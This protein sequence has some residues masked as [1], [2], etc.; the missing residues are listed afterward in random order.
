MEGTHDPD[1]LIAWMDDLIQRIEAHA[2]YGPAMRKAAEDRLTLVLNYHTHGP[3]HG[4]CLSI[5]SRPHP[6]L[7]VLG[8]PSVL[9]ELVHVRGFG[10]TAEE[11]EPLLQLLSARLQSHYRLE[12]APEILIGRR[13]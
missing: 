2:S 12:K 9:K 11:G 8:Q 3:G 10:R 4:Y 6:G 13:S 7:Q 1:P 5:L